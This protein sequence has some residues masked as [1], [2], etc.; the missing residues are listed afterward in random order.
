MLTRALRIRLAVYASSAALLWAGAA[1]H[2]RLTE[3]AEAAETWFGGPVVVTGDA[4]SAGLPKLLRSAGLDSK[5]AER[6]TRA[7]RRRLDLQRLKRGDRYSVARSTDGAF[8]HLTL[9]SGLDRVVVTGRSATLRRDPAVVTRRRIEGS[10]KDSLWLSMEKAGA[11]AQIIA[12]YIDVFQWTVDFFTEPRAGDRFAVVWSEKRAPGG[13]VL[14]RVIEA[15]VY[16]G[17][18]ARGRTAFL[19]EGSYYDEDGESLQRMFLRAPLKFS[20]ISSRFNPN[21]RHPILRTTRPHRGTDYAAPTGTPIQAVADGVVEKV[22]RERGFGNV[23]TI[24]HGR[25]Y[26]T[27]YAH[28]S[29]FAAGI[30]PNVRVKQGRVIGY[31]GA[32]GLA[33]G[34]HLHFE[35]EKQ[36]RWFDF[37]RLKLPFSHSIPRSLRG[38]FIAERDAQRQL[39]AGARTEA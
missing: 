16:D 17:R 6:V 15:A 29:R 30:R 31:V 2:G 33:T 20:R 1:A 23:V 19:F 8:L 24:R 38:R 7:A 37:L 36:G 35:I 9:T 11:P 12:E 3:M 26:T 21:R 22:S 25:D 32:T 4:A 14:G 13:R 28:M 39:L 34:P 5:E 10:L 18:V 27:L